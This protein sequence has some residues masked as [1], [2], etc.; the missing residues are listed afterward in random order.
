MK[1]VR[2]IARV[3]S[4]QSGSSDRK[5][6]VICPNCGQKLAE[7]VS[8]YH[9]GIT[10]CLCRRCHLYILVFTMEDGAVEQR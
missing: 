2:I 10:R 1:R 3:D 9:E 6:L 5:R 7:I 8:A 4:D